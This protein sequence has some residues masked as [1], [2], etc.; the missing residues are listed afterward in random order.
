MIAVGF[1]FP[2]DDLVLN[3]FFSIVDPLHIAVF[4]T[5]EYYRQFKI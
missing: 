1:L 2:Q 5:K 3:D 4:S